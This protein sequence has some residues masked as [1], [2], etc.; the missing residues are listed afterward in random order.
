MEA[1]RDEAREKLKEAVAALEN[2]RLG[3]LHVHAG[4]G[5]VESMTM[6][7]Q[8][9]RGLSDDTENLLAGHL[10]VERIL[11]E[12]RLTGVFTNVKEEDYHSS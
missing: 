11:Q 8:A 6:E 7:I 3:L 1:T 5:T 2:I 12:A 10:E 4:S 9:A